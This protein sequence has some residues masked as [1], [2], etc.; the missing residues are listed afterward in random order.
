MPSILIHPASA[1]RSA[2]DISAVL[3]QLLQTP[4]GHALVEIQG[5]LNTPSGQTTQ[6]IGR[7][8]FPDYQAENQNND[9]QKRV[10]LYV[11]K[12]QRLTGELK[13]LLK[14]LALLRKSPQARGDGNEDLEIAEV[15]YYKLLFMHRPEP[16]GGNEG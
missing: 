14:P 2:S 10:Y 3:P 6:S 8:V 5:T 11:G 9:W 4:S 12:H 15:V 16:V 1:A 13:K 7:L